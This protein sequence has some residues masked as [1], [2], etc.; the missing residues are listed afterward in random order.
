M[1]RQF[2]FFGWA[3]PLGEVIQLE[4]HEREVGFAAS[5]GAEGKP[6]ILVTAY[7]GSM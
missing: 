7:W 6:N 4:P 3:D 2:V 5:A 1:T